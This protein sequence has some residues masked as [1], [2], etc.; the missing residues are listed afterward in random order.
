M[1]ISLRICKNE[2]VNGKKRVQLSTKVK[3]KN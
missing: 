1:K 2:M 3:I